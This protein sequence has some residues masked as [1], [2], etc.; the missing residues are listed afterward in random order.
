MNTLRE[1]VVHMNDLKNECEKLRV[2]DAENKV[3]ADKLT[4]LMEL[5][6]KLKAELANEVTEKNQVIDEKNKISKEKDEVG[7]KIM[8]LRTSL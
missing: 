2:K 4:E 1:D 7:I 5:I 6:E 3:S 8:S